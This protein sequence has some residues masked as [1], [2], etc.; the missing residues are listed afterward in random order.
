MKIAYVNLCL[1]REW[2]NGTELLHGFSHSVSLILQSNCH[3]LLLT[4]RTCMQYCL[5]TDDV[6]SMFASALRDMHRSNKAVFLPFYRD[7]KP[8]PI[9]IPKVFEYAH[10]LKRERD[11]SLPSWWSLFQYDRVITPSRDL[12]AL[13]SR[14]V[15]R[16]R[17]R[18]IPRREVTTWCAEIA[19]CTLLIY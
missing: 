2:T 7:R 1:S 15:R 11:R 5:C 3:T 9:R 14:S 10:V 13:H 4:R 6:A 18:E 17:E 16:E 12:N 8:T 19:M